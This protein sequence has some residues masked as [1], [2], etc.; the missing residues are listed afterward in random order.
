MM[1]NDLGDQTSQEVLRE[2][3][4]A[5]NKIKT[6]NQDRILERTSIAPDKD[7]KDIS[8]KFELQEEIAKVVFVLEYEYD[9]PQ[10]LSADFFKYEINR[11]KKAKYELP[12]IYS[13]LIRFSMEEGFW[14]TYISN[15]FPK[16]LLQ[17]VT[18]L[19]TLDRSLFGDLAGDKEDAALYII[20]RSFV[21]NEVIKPMLFSWMQDHKRANFYEAALSIVCYMQQKAREKGE[22]LVEELCNRFS[23][24]I[25][26]IKSILSELEGKGW[27]NKAIQENKKIH[28]YLEACK[29]DKTE[30][31]WRIASEFILENRL[32][33]EYESL[34]LKS[35]IDYPMKTLTGEKKNGGLKVAKKN[36]SIIEDKI[37]LTVTNIE[38]LTAEKVRSIISGL[39]KE[40]FEQA[41][42]IQHQKPSYFAK[43]FLERILHEFGISQMHVAKIM[44]K[45]DVQLMY[46]LSP[47]GA[48]EF[49]N[50]S[51]DEK[52]LV[53]LEETIMDIYATRE[54]LKEEIGKII[55]KDPALAIKLE[56]SLVEENESQGV[57]SEQSLREKLK[58]STEKDLWILI[59]DE[60]LKELFNNPEELVAGAKLLKKLSLE[61]GLLLTESEATTLITTELEKIG[62]KATDDNKEDIDKNICKIIYARLKDQREFQ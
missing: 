28:T 38:G 36:D 4:T 20:E 51:V 32:M 23:A 7:I 35:K 9:I 59:R 21:I 11:L 16:K 22:I 54:D 31:N 60:Y 37:A 42:K 41:T 15:D 30:M 10:E 40:N 27:A 34:D 2:A 5:F 3:I 56:N 44:K 33:M 25:D 29:K 14:I 52:V 55:T 58:D 13:F 45:F 8:K 24:N 1:E 26:S 48:E 61:L 17:R 50:L 19:I 46:R 47:M 62:L 6:N 12:D 18:K 39:V 49:P 57:A 53:F 43:E